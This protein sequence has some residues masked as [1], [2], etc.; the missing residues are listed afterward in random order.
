[1][2]K[3]HYKVLWKMNLT[4]DVAYNWILRIVVANKRLPLP[5]VARNIQPVS[6]S[7]TTLQWPF[8]W[9][10]INLIISLIESCLN[11]KSN[12]EPHFYLRYLNCY[13][14]STQ[15]FLMCTKKQKIFGWTLKKLNF[16]PNSFTVLYFLNVTWMKRYIFVSNTQP[17]KLAMKWKNQT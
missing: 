11:A 2:K 1:M 10:W 17:F 8:R 12:P 7:K 3:S 5:W 9:K 13:T 4:E 16:Q 6:F 15:K 14:Q